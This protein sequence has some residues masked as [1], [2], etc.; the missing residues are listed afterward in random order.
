MVWPDRSS[1]AKKALPPPPAPEH[2]DT[3]PLPPH[4]Q[5]TPPPPSGQLPVVPPSQPDPWL[6]PQNQNQSDPD[7]LSQDL[8]DDDPV[9]PLA[10]RT[11]RRQP[12]TNSATG[13]AECDDVIASYRELFR[14]DKMQAVGA[15]AMKAQRDALDQMIQTWRGLKTS[16]QAVKDSTA[17]ACRQAFDGLRQTADALGC[18]I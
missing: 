1:E 15:A 7:V 18:P 8:D 10:T 11:G 13:V 9:D 14:C 4:A 6:D 12:R 2:M 5:L 17:M 3:S 16:P